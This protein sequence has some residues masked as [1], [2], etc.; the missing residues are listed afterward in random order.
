MLYTVPKN[1]LFQNRLEIGEKI[2]YDGIFTMKKSA[3]KNAKKFVSPESVLA[4]IKEP[5]FYAIPM[6]GKEKYA[7][8][9]ILSRF[10]G[11][12]LQK[13]ARSKILLDRGQDSPLAV[14][15][16]PAIGSIKYIDDEHAFAWNLN[17]LYSTES[18][19]LM[20]DAGNVDDW[21]LSVSTC[22]N[23]Q[24]VFEAE[25]DILTACLYAENI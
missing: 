22:M 13:Y 15:V 25:M 20:L 17:T 16:C 10:N 5:E 14:Y 8:E 18:S 7:I 4:W 24:S 1:V 6:N 21:N 2:I 12:P 19:N 11:E 23:K 3:I 9:G